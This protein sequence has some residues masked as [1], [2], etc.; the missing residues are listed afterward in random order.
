MELRR[1]TQRRVDLLRLLGCGGGIE[2]S[3][4]GAQKRFR[5]VWVGTEN[6]LTADDDEDV[7]A[8]DIRGGRD[9]VL[10]LRS[11]HDY[12]KARRIA[13]RSA[14]LSMPANGEL[15]RRSSAN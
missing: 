9:H 13:R 8:G 12:R 15:C 10:E 1:V 2:I 3:L 5:R 6:G 14:S 11:I 4:D 7:L